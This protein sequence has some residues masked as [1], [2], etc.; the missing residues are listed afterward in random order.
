MVRGKKERSTLYLCIIH[1]SL[2][3]DSVKSKAALLHLDELWQ[4]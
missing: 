4:V 1:N 3:S 2:P